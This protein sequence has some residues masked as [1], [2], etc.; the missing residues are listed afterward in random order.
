[1]A[2]QDLVGK[3][4]DGY[5]ILELKGKGRYCTVYKAMDE[6]FENA[7]VAVKTVNPEEEPV[8]KEEAKLLDRL[9]CDNIPKVYKYEDG[10][11]FMEYFENSLRNILDQ[12]GK[13]Q[14]KQAS[15]AAIDILKALEHAHSKKQI[16]RDIKPSNILT[17]GKKYVLNDFNLANNLVEQAQEDKKIELSGAM[18]VSV[19]KARLSCVGGT[20]G[21][22]APEQITGTS[23]DADERTDIYS[24]SV[25]LYEMITGKIP[26]GQFENPDAPEWLISTI[27]K[28]LSMRKENR[29]QNAKEMRERLEKG[30]EGKL[31]DDVLDKAA[32]WV[33]D[34]APEVPGMLGRAAKAVGKGMWAAVK[35]TV[36]FPV[37]LACYNFKK[38]KEMD[39]KRNWAKKEDYNFCGIGSVLLAIILYAST[40]IITPLALNSHY[41]NQALRNSDHRGKI[42]YVLNDEIRYY[43]ASRNLEEDKQIVTLCPQGIEEIMGNIVWSVDG[44][45]IYFKANARTGKETVIDPKE[46]ENKTKEMQLNLYSIDLDGKQEIIM[47]GIKEYGC[48]ELHKTATVDGR[49]VI[50]LHRTGEGF[51]TLDLETK[52]IERVVKVTPEIE[53]SQKVSPDGKYEIEDFFREG[54]GRISIAKKGEEV[55]TILSGETPAWWHA[56]K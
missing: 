56:D 40:A 34:T 38:A 31:D 8:L 46:P 25:V 35:Y 33:I 13:F 14:W 20:E 29:Y 54:E 7:F 53:Q 55:R 47:E 11:L 42:A 49:E 37:T 41:V 17:D 39:F 48:H 15:K 43:D 18:D 50:Y 9:Q 23:K 32:G 52:K 28:G 22:K 30:L 6:D 51:Y 16:H 24:M 12:T 44:E 10:T 21:Y 1:M 3:V 5:N 27:R 26:L 36:G 4:I 45:R 19:G 2:K